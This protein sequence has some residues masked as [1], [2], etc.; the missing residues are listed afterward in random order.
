MLKVTP[1]AKEKF[2]EILQERDI[3]P[4]ISIRVIFSP[5]M[6]NKFDLILDKEKEGDE[7]VESE[8]GINILLIGANVASALEGKVIDYREAPQ[9]AGFTIS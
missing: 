7:V 4:G 6:S 9:G 2:K 1:T 8:E 5:S 3:D